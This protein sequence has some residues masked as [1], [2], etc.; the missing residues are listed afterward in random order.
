M[1]V[2]MH[3][4]T[5]PPLQPEAIQAAGPLCLQC[6]R[7]GW[8]SLAVLVGY[9]VSPSV[10]HCL[11]RLKLVE[12][13][14]GELVIRAGKQGN[15]AYWVLSGMCFDTAELVRGSRG[16]CACYGVQM[17]EPSGVQAVT[18]WRGLRAQVHKDSIIAWAEGQ[19]Q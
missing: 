2:V 18:W 16:W 17:S 9:H 4:P 14:E 11:Q 3:V 13:E 5:L 8:Q 7:G 1:V 12:F 6:H 10:C 15:C 19:Q